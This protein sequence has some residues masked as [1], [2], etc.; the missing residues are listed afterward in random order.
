MDGERA[1]KAES[2]VGASIQVGMG[3]T[4]EHWVTGTFPVCVYYCSTYYKAVRVGVG[5]EWRT[6]TTRDYEP[7]PVWTSLPIAHQ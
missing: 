3:L 2:H 6:C 5:G 4:M 7:R 1:G